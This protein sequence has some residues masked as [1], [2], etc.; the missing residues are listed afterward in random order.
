MRRKSGENAK[1]LFSDGKKPGGDEPPPG[2]LSDAVFRS[3]MLASLSDVTIVD[4]T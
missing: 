1:V 2:A 3:Q 4:A